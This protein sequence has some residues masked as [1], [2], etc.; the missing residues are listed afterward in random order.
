M[1]ISP[2]VEEY[3]RRITQNRENSTAEQATFN[4]KFGDKA[5]QVLTS[6]FPKL[7]NQIVT[8][9]IIDTSPEE[10]FSIG[11]FIVRAGE[12]VRYIPVVMSQGDIASAEMIYDKGEDTLMPLSMEAI[13]DIVHAD[14]TRAETLVKSPMVEDTTQ[15]FRHMYRPPSSSNVVFAAS[16]DISVLPDKYKKKLS[17]H[18]LT[19]PG[20]LAKVAGFY[21]L[22][23]LASKLAQN[24]MASVKDQDE[25]LSNVIKL[26]DLTAKTAS[27]LS[28]E[29]KQNILKQGFLIY[30]EAKDA[31][32]AIASKGLKG[33][34][35]TQLK[36]IE[37]TRD[38]LMYGRGHLFRLDGTEVVREECLVVADIVLTKR[39]IVKG[40]HNENIVLSDFRD[41]ITAEDLKEFGANA[42]E[43]FKAQLE[44]VIEDRSGCCNRGGGPKKGF[45]TMSYVFYPTKSGAYKLFCEKQ[46]GG[47]NQPQPVCCGSGCS[48]EPSYPSLWVSDYEIRNIDGNVYFQSKYDYDGSVGFIDNVKAGY[49][50]ISNNEFVLPKNSFVIHPRI[51]NTA[52]IGHMRTLFK[53]FRSTG[54]LVRMSDN[55]AGVTIAD[56]TKSKTASFRRLADA[57]E[58]LVNECR[59]SKKAVDQ[60]LKD[61]EVLVLEKQAFLSQAPVD[62]SGTMEQVDTGP[63]STGFAPEM[64][65]GPVEVDEEMLAAI[66]GIEDQDLLDTGMLAAIAANDD[67]KSLLVDMLPQFTETC[68]MLGKAI[69][70]F[71]ANQDDIEDFYGEEDFGSLLGRLRKIFKMLGD[72]VSD[73]RKYINM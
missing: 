71:V 72:L 16:S 65:Q 70:L 44:P 36:L 24:K 25:P 35:E 22:D 66:S 34:M 46:R 18:F 28:S 54:V 68:T 32:D 21:P 51:D 13:N 11:A 39:G 27:Q 43:N 40:Y 10:G 4:K 5:Y 42:P 23:V 59:F 8:F 64:D 69:L 30:K 17:D 12:D 56:S 73:L 55:G 53:L 50:R 31:I 33:A 6:K 58:Y 20:L 57:V 52:Y 61:K 49:V 38:T 7:L 3:Q 29:E 47:T 9:K 60:L 1:A 67:I 45:D 37:K 48:S 41:G 15:L 2:T 62:N 63:Y 14:L 19:H 26:Y